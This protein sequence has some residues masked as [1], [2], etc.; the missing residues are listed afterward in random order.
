M[1]NLI[2]RELSFSID[3]MR[4]IPSTE[5]FGLRAKQP[6]QSKLTIRRFTIGSNPMLLGKRSTDGLEIV[7]L[8]SNTVD[9]LDGLNGLA[10]KDCFPNPN[11]PMNR[12]MRSISRSLNHSIQG[13]EEFIND[14]I[15]TKAHLGCMKWSKFMSPFLFGFRNNISIFHLE[16]TII[17]LKQTLKF[18][19][20][21]KK[22]NGNI[23]FVNTSPKYSIL[24][25]KVALLLNQSYINDRWIGGTLTNWKQLSQSI[26]LFKKFMYQFD[27]FLKKN[28][29]QITTYIKAKKRYEGLV[30]LHGLVAS[31]PNQPIHSNQTNHQLIDGLEIVNRR[32]RSVDSLDRSRNASHLS[33]PSIQ[34]PIIPN[35]AFNRISHLPDVIIITNPEKNIIVIQEALK[36]QIPIIGFVDSNIGHN[37]IQY[38]IPGNNQSTEFIYF[39][40][41]LFVI[42][43][44]TNNKKI[45][46]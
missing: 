1:N 28:N 32:S 41:N 20:S 19:Q 9:S 3:Q 31:H 8:R 25:K 13:S 11:Q 36:Y 40:F 14:L 10:T 37:N 18:L 16:E 17:C 5:W 44:N 23:L 24:V 21:I 6:I 22:K 7:S 42:I 30:G 15:K 43:L 46:R 38:F 26:I 4:S 35:H 39:C 29:I 34:E 27:F 33:I 12:Q 45:D 2:S